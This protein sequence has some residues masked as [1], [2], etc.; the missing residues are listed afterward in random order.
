MPTCCGAKMGHS[1]QSGTGARPAPAW[2]GQIQ[3]E[4][5]VRLG[6]LDHILHNRIT[7]KGLWERLPSPSQALKEWN[8]LYTILEAVGYIV[9]TLF[10]GASVF[11]SNAHRDPASG[12]PNL[13]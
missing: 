7:I 13:W 12:L 8:R 3:R 2:R 6:W 11:E 10:F 4:E 1:S 9:E 5:I